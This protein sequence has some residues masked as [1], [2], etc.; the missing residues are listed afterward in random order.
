MRLGSIEIKEIAA[1]APMAG[2]ADR[3]M[4]E[5]CAGFGAG[6]CVSEM[7]SAK[8]LT[9]GDR[10]SEQLMEISDGERPMAIQIFGDDP[11]TMANSV[12]RV[13]R[14]RPDAI[15]INMGCPAP[16]ITGGGA[17]SALMKRPELCGEIVREVLR[18][19]G[20]V[21]VTVKVRKGWDDDSVNAVEVAK[22]CEQSG[23]AAITVH[24]RTREQ[25]YA[26][27]ADL[28]IIE[29]VRRAV[30]VPVIGNGD[31]FTARDAVDMLEK[32]GC[33]M[34][35]IGRGALG[36]PWIF[37]EISAMYG[38]GVITPEPGLYERLNVMRRHITALIEYKGEYVGMREA[39]KHTAWY[40]KGFRGAAKLRVECSKLTK[41]EDLDRLI[42]LIAQNADT[43]L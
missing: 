5:L 38:H 11:L 16:K 34:V 3:A 6:Y 29:A 43:T 1:L 22:I 15:D 27:P 41:A 40:L 10:K 9:L 39:R 31:I 26:P 12:E 24:A 18:A 35:M 36:N 37:R 28:S 33:A 2:V 30:S 20:N 32:T 14:H 17:G 7:V 8:A 25:M 21:P 19:A 4:R 42:E 13:L 23:A